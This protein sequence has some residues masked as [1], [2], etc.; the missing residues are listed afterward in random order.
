MSNRFLIVDEKTNRPRWALII[1]GILVI[2]LLIVLLWVT[3]DALDDRQL[4]SVIVTEPT[5]TPDPVLV[6][7]LANNEAQAET[8]KQFAEA[9]T[10]LGKKLEALNEPA[11]TATRAPL[12]TA[13]AQP[14]EEESATF[15]LQELPREFGRPNVD[16]ITSGSG[17]FLAQ[18]IEVPSPITPNGAWAVDMNGGAFWVSGGVETAVNLERATG[19]FTNQTGLGTE[20]FIAEKG[21]LNRYCSDAEFKELGQWRGAVQC[22]GETNHDLITNFAPAGIPLVEGGFTMFTT[23]RGTFSLPS[24]VTVH[25]EGDDTT[26]WIVLFRGKYADF[27][28]PNDLN[29]TF[30]V[31]D[32]I[33][34]NIEWIAYSGNPNGGFVSEGHWYQIA[35][36][37]MLGNN[38]CG[39]E[40][41]PYQFAMFFDVNTGGW[42]V[43]MRT[44][45][46]NGELS[47][48]T[49]VDSNMDYLQ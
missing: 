20:S 40:G 28:T 45:A 36:G 32:Y 43:L 18:T 33:P 49:L 12:P 1:G 30:V 4:N 38:N 10:G 25:V 37:A 24:G 42:V 47:N 13:T 29:Q 15:E 41:C 11:P 5:A 6:A 21:K 22:W 39:R 3:L 44:W 46:Q 35:D 2:A 19:E 23:N 31:S 48:W 16:R 17:M 14:A 26:S 27:N 7:I 8:N 9:L 34:G